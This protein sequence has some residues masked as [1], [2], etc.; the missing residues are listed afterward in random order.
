MKIAFI[1][2][3]DISEIGGIENYMANLCPILVENGHEVILYTEGNKYCIEDYKGVTII[4]FKSVKNKFF[5]KIILGFKSTLNVIFKQKNV[6][7]IHYNAMAAGLSSFIP[8]LLGKRVVFQMHGIEWQRSKWSSKSK[9]IIKLLEAFV[10]KI[11]KNIICVSQEQTDYIYNKFKKESVTIFSG[12]NLPDEIISTPI[13]EKYG[14]EENKY[15]L[16]LA[17]LVK[18]KRPDILIKAYNNILNKNIKLVIAGNDNH[19]DKYINYLK[20][21]AKNNKNIVFTGSVYGDDKNNLLSNCLL[22]CT[23]S[24][25]EGLPITLLEAMSFKKICIASNIPAHKEALAE[26]GVY[27]EANNVNDLQKEIDNS[28]NTY[29][30]L[31]QLEEL[32]YM[33]IKQN[34]T[35]NLISDKYEQYCIKLLAK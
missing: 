24:E 33:R 19:S 1:A 31:K 7:L 16:F 10:I 17:R 20:N 28:I 30:D 3:R 26:N 11:N 25:L 13:L 2:S 15:I 6:D 12:T 21:L 9:L 29:K 5:N 35:W 8:I 23:P 34:F 18:E 22:Y 27:F 4:T 14:L 32:N